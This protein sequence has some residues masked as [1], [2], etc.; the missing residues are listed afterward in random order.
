MP[1]RATSPVASREAT[2]GG[3]PSARDLPAIERIDVSA[4]V[5][6]TDAPESDG[7]FTWDSTTLIIAEAHAGAAT[8]FGY[9]Y[10]DLGAA[11]VIASTL[12]PVV[13]GRS[14]LD[15]AAACGAMARAVRNAGRSGIAS[16]AISAVDISLWDLKCRLLNLPLNALIGA[17]RDD[18]PIYGSGGFCSYTEERLQRQLA[19][20]V[21][22]GIPR[23][24]MKV[25]RDRTADAGRVRAARAAIGD[26]AELY[27]DANGAWN[28]ARA[29]AM[30]DRFSAAGVSWFEEP[31]SS[32]DVDGLRRVRA[33]AP[34][35]MEVAAGEYGYVGRDFLRLIQHGAV[36]V[37]QVDATR[38]GGVT[39]FLQAA[40]ICDAFAVPL[41]TH[42]APS[43]HAPL[44][45]AAPTLRHLEYFH[46]HV[47]IEQWLFD[48][49]PVARDGALAPA[50]RGHP[51][52]G[53]VL[54]RA[55]AAPYRV[56]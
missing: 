18:S 53:L 16:T 17:I 24:K 46:D 15:T 28:A 29:I 19:E 8:G 45:C 4:F 30:A 10:G 43:L 6:P 33:R 7:T 20:W 39:G 25:G 56:V 48:G 2:D 51:G 42:T 44:G 26:D 11:T 1:L 37:L 21:E 35:G 40:A 34:H 52:L 49:A 22:A 47:R 3:W 31:V 13:V 12:A 14:P 36:D 54:K 50:D 55:D 38:C 9:T 27:V 32:D 5:V 41:S 23:V